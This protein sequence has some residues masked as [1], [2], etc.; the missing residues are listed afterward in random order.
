[1]VIDAILV[2]MLVGGFEL[3]KSNE[4][5]WKDESKKLSGAEWQTPIYNAK[6]RP[7]SSPIAVMEW[8]RTR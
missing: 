7:I 3:R 4:A 5:A 1:M 6:E 2:R 8:R